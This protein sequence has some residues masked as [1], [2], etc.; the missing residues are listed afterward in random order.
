MVMAHVSYTLKKHLT[1][2]K[3]DYCLYLKLLFYAL[4]I[5]TLGLLSLKKTHLKLF[6]V[7]I[8]E[9]MGKKPASTMEGKCLR[10]CLMVKYEVV[11]C[12]SKAEKLSLK[13]YSW[14][15]N[16]ADGQQW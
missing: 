15:L 12:T 14:N 11:C 13:Q 5:S 10:K 4:I 8:E 16:F 9:L 2:E 1:W 6:S 7:D 3:Y